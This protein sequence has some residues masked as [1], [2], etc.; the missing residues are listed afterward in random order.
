MLTSILG[1]TFLRMTE[2]TGNT[3]FDADHDCQNTRNEVL[4]R[5]STITV[6][7]KDRTDGKECIVILGRW[8]DPY[9]SEVF[10]DPKK[11]QI[12]HLVPLKN[13]HLSGGWAWDKTKKRLFANDLQDPNHLI[14]VKAALN[15]Q[16]G[17]KGPDEWVPPNEDF[18]CAYGDVWERIKEHWQ[19]TM[20][21]KEAAA[22]A[23]L[24]EN[25]S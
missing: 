16:K 3:G 18:W 12:D 1:P 17:A 13:A 11:L 22:I 14:S 21:T 7:F 19:L 23:R 4:I 5:E 20:T 10:T 6:T 25:C 24:K 8:V 15:Q 9:S 2:R